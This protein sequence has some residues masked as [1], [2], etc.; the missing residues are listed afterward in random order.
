[1]NLKLIVVVAVLAVGVFAGG[2]AW[3]HHN[4]QAATAA[5][6]QQFFKGQGQISD[7]DGKQ[8]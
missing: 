5:A 6:D 2:M 4:Q 8:W 1:M 7:T 3:E